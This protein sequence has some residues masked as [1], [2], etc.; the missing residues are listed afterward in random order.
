M[1]LIPENLKLLKAPVLNQEIATV[2][3]DSTKK[4]L[5]PWEGT[6]PLGK[7]IAAIT[8]LLSTLID[9]DMEENDIIRKFSEMEQVLLDLHCQDTLARR[10]LITYILDKSF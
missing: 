7:G 5:I 1:I 8:N 9:G 4:R 2:L 10:K 3:S 6:K